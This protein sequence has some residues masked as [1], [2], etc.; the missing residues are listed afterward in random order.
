M[1]AAESLAVLEDAELT[2]VGDLFLYD[3]VKLTALDLTPLSHVTAVGDW[4]L[5]DCPRLTPLRT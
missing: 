4:F 2:T 3:C 5:R 1:T